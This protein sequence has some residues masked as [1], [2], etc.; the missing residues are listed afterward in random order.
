[1][2]GDCVYTFC[3]AVC[4]ETE[5]EVDLFTGRNEL[6]TEIGRIAIATGPK[7]AIRAMQ[8][9]NALFVVGQE[10]LIKFQAGVQDPPQ[11][12]VLL[13]IFSAVSYF[14]TVAKHICCVSGGPQETI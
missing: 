4:K 10:Y 12:L 8:A 11:V 2:S 5:F 3:Y 1:M 14:E 7:G 9:A 6:L 13:C